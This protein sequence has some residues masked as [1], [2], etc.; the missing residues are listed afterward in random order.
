MP[1]QPPLHT[2]RR[3]AESFGTA[4]DEYDRHRPRYPQAL[5]ADLVEHEGIRTVDV[6]AG[7]G[8]ASAQLVEA[9]AHYTALGPQAGRRRRL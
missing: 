9:G 5:V 2:D 6:G 7:T 1:E 8:I 3:R 4:A